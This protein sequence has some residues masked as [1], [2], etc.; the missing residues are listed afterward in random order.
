MSRNTINLMNA[1]VALSES[2]NFSRAARKLRISQPALTKQVAALEDLVGVTL[3]ERDRHSVSLNDAGR[4]YVEHARLALLHG[5][6]ALRAARAAV[7]EA[8]LV[9]NVG[10]SPYTDPFLISTLLSLRLPLHPQLRIELASRYSCDQID[11]LIAGTLDLAI[12][13]EPPESALITKVQISQSPF[14]IAMSNEDELARQASVTFESLAGRSWILFERRLHS[15]LYDSV[16][17]LAGKRRVI[18]SKIQHVSTPEEA[19]P[20][21]SEGSSIAFVVK[22]GALR[23]ARNGLTVRPLAE[24]SLILK[25]Y[26]AS[27]ANEQSKAVSEV[28]R[29][30][31]RKI[32]TIGKVQQL[33]LRIPTSS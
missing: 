1:A 33:P 12:A 27:R 22:A 15:P 4:A 6:R 8:D 11:D 7:Q 23:I 30:F 29:A 25:T 20:F 32:S 19:F 16:M 9:L 21:I 28:V 5:E 2:L 3:F 24:D 14:Y 10:R 17:S 26:L 31:M 18:P 13:T